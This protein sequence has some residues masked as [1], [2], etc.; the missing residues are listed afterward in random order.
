MS[1]ISGWEPSVDLKTFLHC[2]DRSKSGANTS[3]GAVQTS[4]Q[5]SSFPPT[6][7]TW[8]LLISH[9]AF[10]PVSHP[11]MVLEHLGTGVPSGMWKLLY[12]FVA[13]DH[14]G[15]HIFSKGFYAHVSSWFLRNVN[16]IVNVCYITCVSCPELHWYCCSNSEELWCWAIVKI[17]SMSCSMTSSCA[18]VHYELMAELT[19][20]EF[21]I[22]WRYLKVSVR[23]L[24]LP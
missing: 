17:E 22:I 11:K 21:K 8:F 10:P 12:Q 1:F 14:E 9:P 15:F 24:R 13:L 16:S 19:I 3:L 2:L 4:R 18:G 7:T 5:S 6:S 23:L 20:S